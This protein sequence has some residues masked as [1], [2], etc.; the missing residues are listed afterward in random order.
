MDEK[1]NLLSNKRITITLNDEFDLISDDK[2]I[3]HVPVHLKAGNY[4]LRADFKGDNDYLKNSTSS[5]I[6][7]K[8]KVDGNV[9]ID[10]YQDNANITVRF[11]KLINDVAK[12][13]INGII[14]ITKSN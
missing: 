4:T 6:Y 1:G 9:N 12:F 7:V 10:K 11:S 8:C 2:G 13:I 14:K 3:V 5:N